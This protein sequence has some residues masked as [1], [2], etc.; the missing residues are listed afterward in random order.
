MNPQQ[1]ADHLRSLGRR[2]A[3]LVYEPESRTFHPSHPELQQLADRLVFDRRDAAAH[4]AI[5]FEVGCET[6][7]LMAIFIHKTVRGQAQGG[8]RNRPYDSVEELLREGL[9]LSRGMTHKNA[10]AGLWWG[11]G[12]GLIAGGDGGAA[13]DPDFRRCLYREYGEFVSSLR[14]CYVTAQDAGTSPLDI[15]EVDRTT[16]FLTCVP[17][18]RGGSGNPSRMTAAGVV[19][20]ME[21]ALHFLGEASLEDK[22]IVLQ[23][24]GNVGSAMITLLLHHGVRQIVASEIREERRALL[25]DAF[26]DQPVEIR[27]T[28]LGDHEILG[29]PC[30]ILAPCALGGVLG[31]KTISS[32]RAKIVCG[33]A[34]DQLVDENRDA[35]ELKERGI[36]CVPDFL[37]NRMGI[38]ACSNEQYGRVNGD[39]AIQRHLGRSWRNGIYLTTSK[40][41]DLARKPGVTPI[42]AAIRLAEELARQPHPI[43]GHRARQ[44]VE[45]LVADHWAEH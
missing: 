37:A 27:P 39:R 10:L 15:T 12:K 23:G 25:L 20:A 9:R 38:V 24:A 41:L 26:S 42:S 13:N 45:S 1:F 29:E 35:L 21:A 7:A 31:P 4:E 30:D 28:G 18:E 3:Y 16:R 5:F 17:P 19:C 2:R 33:A 36:T 32:I 40:V 11:G 43:W 34:N 6:G 44:I 8:V 22:K 14:G